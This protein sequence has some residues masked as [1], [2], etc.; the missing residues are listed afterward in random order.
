[1][2]TDNENNRDF[3]WEVIIVIAMMFLFV[4]LMVLFFE[5]NIH[6]VWEKQL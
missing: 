6:L 5:I 3:V 1:M 2:K 4:L